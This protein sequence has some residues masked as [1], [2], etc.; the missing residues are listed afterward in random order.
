MCIVMV[1]QECAPVVKAGGLGD[2]VSRLGR[3]LEISGNPVQIALPGYEGMRPE[4][5]HGHDRR[6]GLVA[7]AL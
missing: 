5:I 7:G 4:V 3:V 2:V 6:A 1:V